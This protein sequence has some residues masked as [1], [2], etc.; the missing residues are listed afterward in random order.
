MTEIFA[1]EIATWTYLDE[2]SVYNS[3]PKSD[4]FTTDAGYLAVLGSENIPVGFACSG[5]EARVPGLSDRP[6]TLDVGLGMNPIFVGQRHGVEF[7][8]AVVS[9]FQEN[10]NASYLRVVVQSWNER[11]LNVARNLGFKESGIHECDQNGS[12][13][14]YTIL[15]KVTNPIQ[16][17]V[18]ASA[19]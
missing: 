8:V 2:W 11:S 4:L 15:L 14:A 13:I 17:I 9:Y 12:F 3:S 18:N 6:D 1:R 5:V 19:V 10:T 7:G 16:P